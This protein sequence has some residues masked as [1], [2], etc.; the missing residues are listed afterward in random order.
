VERARKA[1]ERAITLS[2]SFALG[3]LV[4]G[5]ATLY[6]GQPKEAIHQLKYGLRLNPFDPHSFTWHFFLA[7]AHYLADQ[8]IQGLE[9]ANGSLEIRPHCSAALKVAAACEA[10]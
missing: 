10:A 6:L 1:A 4:L 8:H 7:L 5:V 3:H 9:E 2:P